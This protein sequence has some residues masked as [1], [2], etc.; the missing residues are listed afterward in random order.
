M[1]N[2]IP[3]SKKIKGYKASGYWF[4]IHR[5]RIA[6]YLTV[7]FDTEEQFLEEYDRLFKNK[8]LWRVYDDRSEFQL[9]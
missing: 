9:R 7:F 4:G 1:D 5:G 3:T 2:N 6:G 8:P